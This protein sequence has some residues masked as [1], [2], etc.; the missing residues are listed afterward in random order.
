VLHIFSPYSNRISPYS[1]AFNTDMCKFESPQSN[2]SR[3]QSADSSNAGVPQNIEWGSVSFKGS[4]RAPRF[5]GKF[6]FC[7]NIMTVIMKY[8]RSLCRIQT[9][10][11]PVSCTGG[12]VQIADQEI[13]IVA[14]R[15]LFIVAELRR[16]LLLHQT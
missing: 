7:F 6:I 10:S 15:H 13:L 9:P 14:A 8:F 11:R 12:W 2:E 4:I 5:L 16:M 1:N 3:A